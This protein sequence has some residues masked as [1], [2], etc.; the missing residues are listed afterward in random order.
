MLVG[1]CTLAARGQLHFLQSST[2]AQCGRRLGC[3][4]KGGWKQWQG[5]R[6]FASTRIFCF[7]SSRLSFTSFNFFK[8]AGLLASEGFS[9]VEVMHLPA[10]V[11]RSATPTYVLCC[12]CLPCDHYR[13]CTHTPLLWPTKKVPCIAHGVGADRSALDEA[14]GSPAA[15]WA[16]V[17]VTS[18][19]GKHAH[20]P[21]VDRER[22][23]ERIGE[24]EFKREKS[25]LSRYRAWGS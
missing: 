17:V 24:R 25:S 14:L 23:R 21:A 18:P 12:L 22:E 10:F 15:P 5:L 13:L 2:K 9:T 19:E 16:F 11:I 1:V 4:D 7:D 8:L 6:S 20:A 3:V